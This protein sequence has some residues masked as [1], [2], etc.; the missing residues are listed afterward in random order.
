MTVPSSR[1]LNKSFAVQY[2]PTVMSWIHS[3]T[4]DVTP[5]QASSRWS[6]FPPND[7]T[8]FSETQTNLRTG[9]CRDWEVWGRYK[10][11]S[12]PLGSF[13]WVLEGSLGL[14]VQFAPYA[15]RGWLSHRMRTSVW[16][17]NWGVQLSKAQSLHNNHHLKIIIINITR[18]LNRRQQTCQERNWS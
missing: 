2:V 1:S 15:R 7:S 10:Q 3:A 16:W 17:H 5:L 13:V 14:L 18:D 8:S 4:W 12:V 11:F 9:S 6:R